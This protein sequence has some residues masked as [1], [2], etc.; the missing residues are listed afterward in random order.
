VKAGG[1]GIASFRGKSKIGADSRPRGEESGLPYFP[2]D[3]EKRKKHRHWPN[4][5]GLGLPI[6]VELLPCIL[7]ERGIASADV[8]ILYERRCEKIELADRRGSP[9]DI[10]KCAFGFRGVYAEEKMFLNR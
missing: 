2:P 5:K 7:T 9:L 8:R 6:V 10:R 1:S 3:R 4:E